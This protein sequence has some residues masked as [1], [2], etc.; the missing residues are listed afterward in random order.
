M[1]VNR[2][3]AGF[4]SVPVLSITQDVRLRRSSFKRFRPLKTGVTK[5]GTIVG[6]NGFALDLCEMHFVIE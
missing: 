1:S 3:A 6:E 4:V 2:F 5:W